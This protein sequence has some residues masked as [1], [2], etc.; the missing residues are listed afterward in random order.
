MSFV[1]QNHIHKSSSSIRGRSGPGR[2]PWVVGGKGG[3]C[4]VPGCGS[5]SRP[6]GGALRGGCRTLRRTAG[7]GSAPG[8]GTRCHP[9]PSCHFSRPTPRTPPPTD[10]ARLLVVMPVVLQQP[11]HPAAAISSPAL[12]LLTRPSLLH[13]A[14]NLV[15]EI[16]SKGYSYFLEYLTYLFF[17]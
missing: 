2:G 14:P 16:K 8:S 12:F 11:S 7:L 10:V 17:W 3:G 13:F 15:S 6:A 4:L 1:Q 9:A 5:S